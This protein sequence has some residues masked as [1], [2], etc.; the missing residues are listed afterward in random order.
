MIR[1]LF[2]F[3]PC[4]DGIP[5]YLRQHRQGKGDRSL[6]C[7]IFI[8]MSKRIVKSEWPEFLCYDFH[9][10][11]YSLFFFEGE[12]VFPLFSYCVLHIPEISSWL[13]GRQEN[14]HAFIN[15]RKQ[16][17]KEIV[18]VLISMR[19]IYD[20]CI[21]FLMKVAASVA[22]HT[23][24]E[25]CYPYLDTYYYSSRKVHCRTPYLLL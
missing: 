1:V 16:N 12:C 18:G 3:W 10:E 20:R 17:I 25:W 11:N 19:N 15:F 9:S 14:T 4:K 23:K 8:P 6:F 24:V 2:Y 5:L 13:H 22:S 21:S 7:S